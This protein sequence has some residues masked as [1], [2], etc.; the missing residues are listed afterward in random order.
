VVIRL[1]AN[2]DLLSRHCL[3]T[4]FLASYLP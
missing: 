3:L 4:L 1:Q 2:A